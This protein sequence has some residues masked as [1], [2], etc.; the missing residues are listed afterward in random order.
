[1]IYLDNAAT[2]KSFDEVFD[3]M[4]ENNSEFFYNPSASYRL[5]ILASSKLEKART[6]INERLFGN[7][8]KLYFTSSATES[9][10]TVF[11]GLHLRAGQTVLISAGEHPSV[12]ESACFQ[13]RELL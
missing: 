6:T 10:N 13:K 11:A 8:G 9:N 2:T 4:K 12:Y 1:M 3:L 7:N 5:A